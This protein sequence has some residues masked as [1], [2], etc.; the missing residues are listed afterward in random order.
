MPFFAERKRRSD[1]DAAEAVGEDFWTDKLDSTVRWKLRYVIEDAMQGDFESWRGV[2]KHAV[3]TL[4][5]PTLVGRPAGGDD[6]TAALIDG[7][8]ET[9]FTILELCDIAAEVSRRQGYNGIGQNEYRDRVRS[10]LREHRVKFD[11]IDGIVVPF[12]SMEMHTA[13]VE[14]LVRLLHGSAD[15]EAVEQAYR[16]AL[17]ELHTGTADD[18]ITDAATALQE[19]LG[20]YGC[21]GNTVSK[22]LKDA[23]SKGIFSPHDA[24]LVAALRNVGEWVE[25]DRSTLGDAHSAGTIDREDG[26]LIVHIVGALILRLSQGPRPQ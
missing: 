25:A 7:S 4:G 8:E 9:V 12:E 2:W 22:R 10:I 16:K 17:D 6:V 15:W 24:R 11:L 23:Q 26:W 19:A 3:R 5:V 20:I 1:R 21:E 13:I 18:A 14:P